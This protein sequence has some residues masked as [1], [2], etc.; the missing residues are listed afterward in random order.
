MSDAIRYKEAAAAS[1]RRAQ[2]LL[3]G[4]S[5]DH[6][7]ADY[8]ILHA[9]SEVRYVERVLESVREALEEERGE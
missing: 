9:M 8:T 7:Q 5:P 2:D 4:W 6:K 3:E 1:L